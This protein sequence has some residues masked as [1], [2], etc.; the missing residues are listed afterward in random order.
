V[1]TRRAGVGDL[2]CMLGCARGLR[3][4]HPNSWMVVISPPGCSELAASSGLPDAVTDRGSLFHGFISCLRRRGT[5]YEPLLPDECDPPRPQRLHLAEE[6]ARALDVPADLSSVAFQAPPRARR[7]LARRLRN[8]NPWQRPIVVFHLGPTWPV[9]EWPAENW[10]ELAERVS[11]ST[12]AIMIKIGIDL[13][14]MGQVRP[15]APIPNAVDWTNQLDISETAALLELA[16]VFVGV[17]SGPLHIAGA[18]GVPAVGLFGP[19]SGHLRLHPRSRTTIVSSN[20]PCLGCH[21]KPTGQLHWKTGCPYD[22]ACM[23]EITARDVFTAV[24]AHIGSRRSCAVPQNVARLSRTSD[25]ST[26]SRQVV[27]C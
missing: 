17:D 26:C 12:S 18:L 27:G 8:V 15:C 20:A 16:A 14:S 22:I 10:R 21:H 1:L 2:A 23:R 4:R 3:G 7:L 9:R 24:A 13:D 5:F 6:F 11:E 25:N 19:I